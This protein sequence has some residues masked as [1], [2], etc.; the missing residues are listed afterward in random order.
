MLEAG[1]WLQAIPVELN[2]FELRALEKLLAAG[3]RLPE[4]A[5]AN[6]LSYEF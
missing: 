3:F 4:N 5:G 6:Y 1:C 2:I